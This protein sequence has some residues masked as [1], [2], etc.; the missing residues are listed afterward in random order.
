MMLLWRFSGVAP[1]QSIYPKTQAL[2]S[3]T[4]KLAINIIEGETVRNRDTSVPFNS[5]APFWL[6]SSGSQRRTVLFGTFRNTSKSVRIFLTS[7]SFLA[8][9]AEPRSAQDQRPSQTAGVDNTRMGA[10]RALAELSYEAFQKGDR[11]LAAKLARIL[12]RAWAKGED[13]GG[14]RALA[15]TDPDL[16]EKANRAM[17][18][19]SKPLIDCQKTTPDAL[20]V[21]SAYRLFLDLLK[22]ADR[23]NS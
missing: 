1:I 13:L 16:F 15:N 19:F 22:Q 10:Y 11:L 2:T 20:K 9:T 8:A 17:A 18:A 7:L 12:E 5:P 4:D 3:A 14:R 6:R 23:E 21:G